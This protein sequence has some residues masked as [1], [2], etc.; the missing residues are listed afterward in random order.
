MTPF[1]FRLEKVLAWRRTQVELEEA[2]FKQQISALNHLDRS[3]AQ[4]EAAG[5][6]AEV[7]VRAWAPLDGSD[8]SALA[9][10]RLHVRHQEKTIAARRVE[11]QKE[12][13]ARKNALL[14]ARRRCQLMERLKERQLADWQA[15]C[16]RE[17]EE[18]A[19]D[20][21]LAAIARRRASL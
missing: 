4:L 3:R 20:S 6:R 18:T 15:A 9:G 8:L 16:D 17:L 2:R 10:F 11:A 21:H 5:I 13:E 7:E 12:L 1:R 19:A 14:E